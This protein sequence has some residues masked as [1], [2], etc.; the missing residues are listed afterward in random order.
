MSN[1]FS[2]DLAPILLSDLNKAYSEKSPCF[3]DI[4]KAYGESTAS[5]WVETQITG[6]DFVTQNKESSDIKAVEEFSRLFVRQYQNI[7]LTEFLLFIARFKL[8]IYGKFYSYFDVVTIGD[9]FRKFLKDRNLEIN[10]LLQ[11]QGFERTSAWKTD[12]YHRYTFETLETAEPDLSVD[13]ELQR[14][15]L[16]RI[17]HN[18]NKPN[19]EKGQNKM[20]SQGNA[21]KRRN[22]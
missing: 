18:H 13:E 11:R 20:D 2:S 5:L 17:D 6:L 3:S 19:N 1:A 9:A 10:K 16:F 21:E 4:D 22:P 12:F 14:R 8:G 15:T 7:K